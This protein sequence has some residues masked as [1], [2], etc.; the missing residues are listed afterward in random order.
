LRD[1]FLGLVEPEWF[2]DQTYSGLQGFCEWLT[3]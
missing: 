3:A 2:D 1:V